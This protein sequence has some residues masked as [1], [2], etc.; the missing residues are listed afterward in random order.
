VKRT[1]KEK[2]R[3]ARCLELNGLF[4]TRQLVSMGAWDPTLPSSFKPELTRTSSFYLLRLLGCNSVPTLNYVFLLLNDYT[5]RPKNIKK[6]H[7]RTIRADGN[8]V[9]LFA[10]G[11]CFICVNTNPAFDFF[12]FRL[13]LRTVPTI[14]TAHIFCACEG[15]RARR[16]RNGQ[17]AGHADWFCFL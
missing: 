9:A 10:G 4:S 6:Q 8:C 3:K 14:V 5:L 1:Q 12:P 17:H 11:P 13:A 16:E 7:G 15:S 2:S